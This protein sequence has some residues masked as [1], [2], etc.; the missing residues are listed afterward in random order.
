MPSRTTLLGDQVSVDERP[1]ADLHIFQNPFD[2]GWPVNCSHVVGGIKMDAANP[3][4]AQTLEA[5][6]RTIESFPSPELEET[7]FF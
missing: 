6:P 1:K 5:C 7:M 4:T 3:S 2:G